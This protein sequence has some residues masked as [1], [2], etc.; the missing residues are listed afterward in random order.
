MDSD[1]GHALAPIVKKF[2]ND[3]GIK[4]KVEAP[5][6]ITDSFPIAAQAGKGPDMVV[7]AHDKVGEWADSG[8]IAPVEV[9]NEFSNKF[10]PKAWQAVLHKQSIWGY[11]IALETTIETIAATRGPGS[12]L[13]IPMVLGHEA[14]GTVVEV[15]SQ[16]KHLKPGDRVCI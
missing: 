14:A 5:E 15:G 3:Y 11:P 13:P 16:V 10:F 12:S 6:K 7:W 8:L 4:V 2:E 9:S 1:R